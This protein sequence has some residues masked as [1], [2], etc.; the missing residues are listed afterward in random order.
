[1]MERILTGAQ[2]GKHECDVGPHAND[3]THSKRCE[4]GHGYRGDDAV[5]KRMF[6]YVQC[7]CTINEGK[8]QTKQKRCKTAPGT[9][10]C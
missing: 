9:T 10:P 5:P 7:Y 8:Q 2:H 6:L 4:G 1:M 3:E